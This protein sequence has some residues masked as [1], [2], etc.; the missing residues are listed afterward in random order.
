MKFISLKN[1]KGKHLENSCKLDIG[2]ID[3]VEPQDNEV[4]S[5]KYNMQDLGNL[6][7][8]PFHVGSITLYI[9]V[10]YE[11]IYAWAFLDFL[12]EEEWVLFKDYALASEIEFDVVFSEEEKA[13]LLRFLV[14]YFSQSRK[15]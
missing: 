13:R 6:S 7:G 9:K 10:T 5:I 2:L 12:N 14:N 11:D 1:T 15:A 8:F 4:I 3:K